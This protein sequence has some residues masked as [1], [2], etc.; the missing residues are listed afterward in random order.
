MLLNG[1]VHNELHKR[2]RK[3][4]QTQ[5]S[6]EKVYKLQTSTFEFMYWKQRT[7]AERLFYLTGTVSG[8]RVG[9]RAPHGRL[10]R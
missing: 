10:A 4:K 6:N 3:Y 9:L 7:I 5:D 8:P 2:K 1:S